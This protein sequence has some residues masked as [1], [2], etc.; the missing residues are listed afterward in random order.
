M[1]RAAVG[2]GDPGLV[3]GFFAAGRDAGFP[4]VPDALEA[5]LSSPDPRLKAA[6]CWH[7]ALTSV[8]GQPVAESLKK[9]A[10]SKAE[11]A[12][13]SV[14]GA[15]F[16]CDVLLRTLGG[17]QTA[18]GPW[19]EGLAAPEGFAVPSD[20]VDEPRILAQLSDA[21]M[22]E[23]AV[24]VTGS[25]DGLA[26]V[27]EV[28]AKR[29]KAPRAGLD[30]GMRLA[31]GFTPGLFADTLRVAGCP[32]SEEGFGAAEV[33]YRDDG[34]PRE[35]RA[36]PT[37]LS[38]SCQAAVIGLIVAAD[39]PARPPA[40][41]GSPELLLLNLG[42]DA[43]ACAEE[44]PSSR[45]R[46]TPGTGGKIKEPRKIRQVNPVYPS[47]A[48]A[49]GADGHGR[50]RD[51]DRH[52]GMRAVGGGGGRPGP[53]AGLFGPAR[54]HSLGLQPDPSRRNADSGGDDGDGE[55]P[56]ELRSRKRARLAPGPSSMR[57][58]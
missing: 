57:P 31:G 17:P 49:E 44:P 8:A 56:D 36:L 38:P 1:A 55:L 13:P 27:K 43:A 39:P 33:V 24:R 12:T 37:R 47:D 6:A 26:K 53:A 52:L 25:P 32:P 29:Q 2:T 42:R 48:R 40:R 22:R 18:R 3:E 19:L 58:Y 11:G 15:A 46:G 28:H 54:G 16:A 20:V 41:P 5:A 10:Q 7:L 21:E 23:V 14:A 51:G 9:A 34:R 35:I 4:V 30:P 45:R 50:D